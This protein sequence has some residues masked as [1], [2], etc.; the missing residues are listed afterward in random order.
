[1]AAKPAPALPS[2]FARHEVV[3][4]LFV[5]T[6]ESGISIPNEPAVVTASALLG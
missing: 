6:I 1:L 4:V 2:R 3:R 5:P